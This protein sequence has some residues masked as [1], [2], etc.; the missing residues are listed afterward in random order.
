MIDDIDVL[1]FF[2]YYTHAFNCYGMAVL[3]V[4][5]NS[6]AQERSFGEDY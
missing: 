3:L 1:E 5:I 2:D 4:L 6:R